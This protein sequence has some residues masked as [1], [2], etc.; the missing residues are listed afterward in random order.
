M[1]AGVA[2]AQPLRAAGSSPTDSE[3][4]V[5]ATHST[6]ARESAILSP[7]FRL[8]LGSFRLPL[9]LAGARM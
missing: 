1:H 3:S 2:S 4:S 8:M 7:Q 5:S 9:R 6:I